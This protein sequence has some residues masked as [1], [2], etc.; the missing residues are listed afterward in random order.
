MH[1]MCS[2]ITSL[3]SVPTS[4]GSSSTPHCYPGQPLSA[5][6]AS[7]PLCGAQD[8]RNPYPTEQTSTCKIGMRVANKETSKLQITHNRCDIIMTSARILERFRSTLTAAINFDCS[9]LFLEV[10]N[11][12]H[13]LP[14]P[15]SLGHSLHL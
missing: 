8:H 13:Q 7:D 3:R 15:C 12:R 1:R 9:N 11:P 6:Q 14:P 4:N 10:R 5:G 2:Y